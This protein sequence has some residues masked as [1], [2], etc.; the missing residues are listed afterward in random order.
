MNSLSHDFT[1]LSKQFYNNFM[2]LN[3][4]IGVM[5]IGDNAVIGVHDEL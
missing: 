5:M 1:I 3:P 4:D 2:I